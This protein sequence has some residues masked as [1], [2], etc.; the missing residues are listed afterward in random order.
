MR[1]PV[2]FGGLL[3]LFSI[4]APAVDQSAGSIKTYQP[5]AVIAR[6][7]TEQSVQIGGPVHAGDT[8]ITG[9]NGAVGIMFQDGSVLSLGPDTEFLIEEFLFEPDVANVSFLTRLSH[10]TASFLSGAIGR[11][12]PSSVKFKTPDAILGLRGTKVLIKVD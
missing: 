10:G 1:I 7:R 5:T 2:L 3:A 6:D 4:Q 9:A 8:I 12:S 11:I